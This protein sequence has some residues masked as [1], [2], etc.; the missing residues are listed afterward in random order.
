MSARENLNKV[1]FHVDLS[2]PEVSEVRAVHPE[3]GVLGQM[4]FDPT[5]SGKVTNLWT[6]PKHRR[7][8][9][10]TGMWNTAK[11]NGLEVRHSDVQTAKGAAWA[12]RVGDLCSAYSGKCSIGPPG[13]SWETSSLLQYALSWST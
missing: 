4:Y 3:K 9:I 5:D 12:K 6:D 2:D 7:Q 13:S 1:Q 8:G 11:A 10:A